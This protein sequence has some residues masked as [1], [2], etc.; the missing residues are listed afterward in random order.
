[1]SV[2]PQTLGDNKRKCYISPTSPPAGFK[3][4]EGTQQEGA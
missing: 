1:M 4:I 3:Q 2:I